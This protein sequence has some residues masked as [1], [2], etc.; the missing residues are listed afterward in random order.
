MIIPIKTYRITVKKLRSKLINKKIFLKQG[1][2]KR[3]MI[4]VEKVSWFIR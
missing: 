2:E 3:F 1:D 4:A